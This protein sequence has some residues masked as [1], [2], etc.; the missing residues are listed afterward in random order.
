MKTNKLLYQSILLVCGIFFFVSL[1]GQEEVKENV[2]YFVGFQQ[3]IYQQPILSDNGKWDALYEGGEWV[4][5]EGKIVV[6]E[7]RKT[8]RV[9]YADGT[10]W[11]ARITKKELIKEKDVDF[12]DVTRIVF[13]GVWVVNSK[14]MKLVLTQTKKAGLVV[15]LYSRRIID[16]G[17]MI[18]DK[19]IKFEDWECYDR[20]TLFFILPA[21]AKFIQ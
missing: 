18:E 4:W 8:L 2:V 5:M 9:V 10:S 11:D 19:E 21:S 17:I 16:T 6:D 3:R 14:A 12:G 15:R 20:I 13:R 1:L 7:K